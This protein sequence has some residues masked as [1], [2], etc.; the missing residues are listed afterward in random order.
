MAARSA[1]RA[2]RWVNE[3]ASGSHQARLVTMHR[4]GDAVVGESKADCSPTCA[5]LGYAMNAASLRCTLADDPSGPFEPWVSRICWQEG[6]FLFC[7]EIDYCYRAQQAG[8][9]AYQAPE[10]RILRYESTTTS[11]YVPMKLRGHHLGELYF[12]AKHGFKHDLNIVRAN[13][14]C[15]L[16]GWSVPRHASA[17]GR[18]DLL[19]S[20]APQ[21]A[22]GH[23]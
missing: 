15:P 4:G 14:S 12:L 6:F 21:P 7:E 17:V 11:R 19:A 9:S 2:V 22:A 8:F 23:Q 18:A 13:A 5:P 1:I 10:A 20:G 3:L 16:A